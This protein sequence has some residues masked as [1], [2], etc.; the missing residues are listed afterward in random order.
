[1]KGK[2]WL[3]GAGPGDVGLI[4]LKGREVLE[5]A[6]IVVYDSLVGEGIFKFIPQEAEMIDAGKRAGRHKMAQEEINRLLLGKALEGK[7]VVRLKGG[8]PFLFGR[9]GEELALLAEEGIPFEVVPGVA[10]AFAVPAY[11]GIPVTHRAFASSVHVMTGHRKKEEPLQLGIG[12]A[13]R[14]AG[15][16]DGCFCAGGNPRRAAWRRHGS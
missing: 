1:M 10:S 7:Q 2:V 5:Q 9:G 13:F 16:P 8:D 15:I 6:E 14:D 3:V 11:F 12:T 4:T